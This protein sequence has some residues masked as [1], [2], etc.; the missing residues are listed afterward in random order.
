MTGVYNE[1]CIDVMKRMEPC[2]VDLVVTSP[3]YDNLREY[4]NSSTWNFEVF[5][6]IADNLYRV[7]KEGGVVVWVVND[8][9]IDGSETLSSFKQALY[10][11]EIGFN[12]NDTMIWRK[13]NPL[14][15]FKSTRYTPCFEYM[16][17][18]SKGVPKTFNPIMKKTKNGGKVFTSSLK[19]VNA[20]KIERKEKTYTAVESIVDYNVWDIPVAQNH[21]NHPAVYPLE[22]AKRYI[23]SWS[24]EGDLVFDPFLGSGTTGIAAR[25]L[26]REFVGTEMD[27]EY[28]EIAKTRV[29]NAFGNYDAKEEPENQKLQLF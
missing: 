18:F 29:E 5:K 13:P 9:T 11:K 7:V 1:N 14:Q 23:L 15:C 19:Q 21:T 6:E 8:A 25:L 17:I 3:P 26:N 10:F 28:F 22:L 27:K 20:G 24:N 2:S 16:F 4:N 12:V